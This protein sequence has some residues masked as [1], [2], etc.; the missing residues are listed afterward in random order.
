MLLRRI[1]QRILTG[2]TSWGVAASGFLAGTASLL[3]TPGRHAMAPPWRAIRIGL[4][5]L[6]A[7]AMFVY[8]V[9]LLLGERDDA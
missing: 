2:S 7:L 8:A 9:R 3:I 5:L 4:Q 6:M 1:R